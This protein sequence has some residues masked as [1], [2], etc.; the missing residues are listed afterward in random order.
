MSVAL[1]AFDSARLGVAART[2]GVAQAWVRGNRYSVYGAVTVVEHVVVDQ[3][4]GHA[5]NRS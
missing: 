2:V 5:L 4:V 3:R 1:S